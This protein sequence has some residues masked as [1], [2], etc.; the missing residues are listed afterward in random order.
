MVGR[1]AGSV[2]VTATSPQRRFFDGLDGLRFVAAFLIVLHHAGFASAATFRYDLFGK[3]LARADVGVSVFFVLSGFLLYRP[4]VV[5][6]FSGA[7][8]PRTGYFL[9][10][11]FARIYP[12]YWVALVVQLLLGAIAVDGLTGFFLTSALLQVYVPSQAVTGI[13][14]SWSLATEM[15][16]YLLLPFLAA[17]A[18][19]LTATSRRNGALTVNRQAIRLLGCGLALFPISLGFRA[20]MELVSPASDLSWGRVSSLWTPSY[21]EVFGAGMM[22]AVVSAWADLRTMIREVTTAATQRPWMWWVA[23]AA[24]FWWVSTQFD[25]ERGLTVAS[26]E[27]E[28]LRQML[29]LLVGVTAIVPIV[30]AAPKSTPGL[31]FLSTRSMSYLGVVSYGVYLW[32]QAF[33]HWAQ[34]AT[35]HGDIGGNFVLLVVVG[36]IGAVIVGGLSHRFIE[37]P[38]SRLVRRWERR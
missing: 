25:L 29:Y 21:I 30:F 17:A 19:R 10:K 5:A 28:A 6:Q 23:S 24:L 18:R 36:T 1:G 4:F 8:F 34:R 38:A 31:R 12:A 15:G 11:R 32:H 2:Q 33:I 3:F 9:A 7:A 13:T 14:Q 35:G 22:I 26:P 27:R 37:E 20:A 16:F